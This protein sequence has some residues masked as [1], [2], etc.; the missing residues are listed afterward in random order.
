MAETLEAIALRLR[1]FIKTAAIMASGTFPL[2]AKV[3][4]D[5]PGA[6]EDPLLQTCEEC[7]G[8]LTPGERGELD[9]IVGKMLGALG[10]Y[11]AI[12]PP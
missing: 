3:E 9:R 4:M 8:K 1:D 11:G 12:R 5:R 7:L 2:G 10:G 6:P